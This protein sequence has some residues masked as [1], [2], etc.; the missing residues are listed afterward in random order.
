MDH[1]EFNNTIFHKK[2]KKF[3]HGYYRA[4]HTKEER[5]ISQ[6]RH[7]MRMDCSRVTNG[8]SKPEKKKN[9]KELKSDYAAR[10]FPMQRQVNGFS[11]AD[12]TP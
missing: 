12:F 9:T 11:H 3:G 6:H 10:E 1:A 4:L 7:S 2:K 5:P 8:A